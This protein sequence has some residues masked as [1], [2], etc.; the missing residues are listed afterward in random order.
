MSQAEGQDEHQVPLQVSSIVI[1]RTADPVIPD[2]LEFIAVLT[3]TF[4]SGILPNPVVNPFFLRNISESPFLWIGYLF[5]F[6]MIQA[7]VVCGVLAFLLRLPIR[8]FNIFSLVLAGLAFTGYLIQL[9][10]VNSSLA[11]A[12]SYADTGLMWM[13]NLL[14]LFPMAA[15]GWVA[16]ICLRRHFGTWPE[17]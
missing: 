8:I 6:S 14:L 4:I 16:S 7:V 15:A 13:A 1:D 9:A 10:Y 12:A 3:V 11:P 5:G 17:K 2:D